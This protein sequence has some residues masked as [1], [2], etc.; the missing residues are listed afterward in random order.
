MNA[1]DGPVFEFTFLMFTA[2]GLSA[3]FF[4]L[5]AVPTASSGVRHTGYTLALQRLAHLI[6]ET[7]AKKDTVGRPICILTMNKRIQ[8]N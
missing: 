3:S 5:Q 4:C 7:A 2:G 6:A 8:H 1:F